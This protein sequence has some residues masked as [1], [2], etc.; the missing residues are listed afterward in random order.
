VATKHYSFGGVAVAVRSGVGNPV[1]LYQ[2][3]VRSSVYTTDLNG[4]VTSE[5]GYFAFGRF[6]YSEGSMPT[7]RRFTGQRVR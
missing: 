2:D 4:A 5:R 1:F 7:D 3:G 6:R